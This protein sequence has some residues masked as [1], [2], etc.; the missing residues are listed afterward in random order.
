MDDRTDEQRTDD[1][2]GTDGHK[3]GGDGTDDGTDGQGHNVWMRCWLCLDSVYETRFVD[4][5]V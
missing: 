2:D 1:D 3:E 4:N 5:T